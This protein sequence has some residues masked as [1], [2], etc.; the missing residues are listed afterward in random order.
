[1]CQW[2]DGTIV[3]NQAL[4]C[5]CGG[6]SPPLKQENVWC[7]KVRKKIFSWRYLNVFGLTIPLRYHSTAVFNRLLQ[8]STCIQQFQLHFCKAMSIQCTVTVQPQ[9]HPHQS[10]EIIQIYTTHNCDIYQFAGNCTD[11]MPYKAYQNVLQYQ[12]MSLLKKTIQALI[13]S[14]TKT[15]INHQL[16]TIKPIT[17]FLYVARFG[18]YTNKI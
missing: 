1:M 4:M 7:H 9:K 14:I 16:L 6:V 13:V 15:F 17:Y 18:S 2:A 8:Y 10:Y 5:C 3:W 11:V 12:P